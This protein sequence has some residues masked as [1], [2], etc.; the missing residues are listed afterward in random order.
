MLP[1]SVRTGQNMTRD[2][3]LKLR[4]SGFTVNE[5]NEPAPENIPVAT[6]VDT[7]SDTT[8]RRNTIATEDWG[9]GGVDKWRI[10]GG[11]VFLSPN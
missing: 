4:N 3:F 9:L 6:T 11:G 2:H 8:I 7:V 5:E 1:L 10:S